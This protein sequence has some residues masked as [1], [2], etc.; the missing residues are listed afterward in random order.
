MHSQ[1]QLNIKSTVTRAD[2]LKAWVNTYNCDILTISERG[3]RN[4][5]LPRPWLEGCQVR[6]RRIKKEGGGGRQNQLT[7]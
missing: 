5:N 6:F 1:T 7:K 3:D 2:E 4:G